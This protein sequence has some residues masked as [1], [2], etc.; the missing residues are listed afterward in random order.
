MF[1]LT[2]FCVL[3][4]RLVVASATVILNPLCDSKSISMEQCIVNYFYYCELTKDYQLQFNNYVPPPTNY[5]LDVITI[6]DQKLAK[7]AY[8]TPQKHNP[9]K[10][11]QLGVGINGTTGSN[12]TSNIQ[13]NLL[14]NYK[15]SSG[16]VGWVFSAI[17]QYNYLYSTTG[18]VSQDHLYLQQSSY[19]MF[20]KY[21]GIF[22]QVSFL[23]DIP[24]GY[25]YTYNENIGYQLQLFKTDHQNLLFSFGPGVQEIKY[26]ATN[27]ASIT[28]PAFLSQ[29]S[30]NL[31]ITSLLSFNEQLQNIVTP[32][33]STLYS[34]SSL[35]FAVYK[36]IGISLNYQF[37]Y[38]SMPEP[39]KPDLTTVS[40]IN[41][42]YSIN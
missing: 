41:I 15:P 42:V 29:I 26:T 23:R 27:L 30:Y 28:Q 2:I 8:I 39:G 3:A 14:F 7:P 4:T 21:N 1:R 32:R 17:G 38:Y 22:G 9:L 19:Y 35:T 10:G 24:N 20:N 31:D 16:D 37:N 40:G 12:N 34:I 13:A 11:T 6:G 18:G 36:N 25:E 33:N 5:V